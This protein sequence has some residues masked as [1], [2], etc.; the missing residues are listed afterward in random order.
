MEH[1]SEGERGEVEANQDEGLACAGFDRVTV[2]ATDKIPP[3]HSIASPWV[4]RSALGHDVAL[5]SWLCENARTLDGERR[6]YSVMTVL[7]VNLASAFN[8][9]NELKNA[10]LAMFQTFAFLHSQGQKTTS[11]GPPRSSL[12]ATRSTICAR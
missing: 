5:G 12:I 1:N 10:I 8:L 9:E 3:P 6:S 4:R 2:R 11:G 7:S